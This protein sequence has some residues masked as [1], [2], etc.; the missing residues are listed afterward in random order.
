MFDIGQCRTPFC[1]FLFY[2]HARHTKP[3][4]VPPQPAGETWLP[5]LGRR[6]PPAWAVCSCVVPLCCGPAPAAGWE[7]DTSPPA[8][9]CEH[10]GR[11]SPSVPSAIVLSAWKKTTARQQFKREAGITTALYISIIWKKKKTQ[12][13]K[14][15]IVRAKVLFCFKI[16]KQ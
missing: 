13:Y 3:A 4:T 8:L 5:L 11:S 14:W 2:S 16:M 7:T 9:Q 6:F 10:A 12:Q 15:C 1:F